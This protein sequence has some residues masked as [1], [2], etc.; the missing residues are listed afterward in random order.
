M[1]RRVAI[2]CRHTTEREK[3]TATRALRAAAK[4][5]GWTVAGEFFADKKQARPSAPTE[6]RE[7]RRFIEAGK[8][9]VVAVPSLVAIGDTVSLVL[10]EILWL[11][12]QGCALYVHDAGL[13]TVSPVDQVLF[14]VVEALKAVDDAALRS[15]TTG[16]P[17]A[18]ALQPE[19]T[20]YQR[21]VIRA[22][23]SSGVS[24]K[25]V[26]KSLKLSVAMVRAFAKNEK[27]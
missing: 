16:R 10:A 9:D 3:R 24:T 14:K 25:D 5:E 26:A 21:S 2:Y 23:M 13:N 11:Q 7:L 19:L 6:W 18:H 4:K 27:A 15:R 22:A 1:S 17:R 12:D 20:P 8:A